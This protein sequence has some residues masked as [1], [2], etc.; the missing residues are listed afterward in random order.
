[1]AQRGSTSRMTTPTKEEVAA[2][3]DVLDLLTRR[4]KLTEALGSDR[5]LNE[6]D[7]QVLHYIAKHPDCGP[8]DLAR[9]LNVASTTISSATDR[10]VKRDLIERERPEADRRAVS[11][12]LTVTGR[13][14]VDS[15]AESYAKLHR[16]MLEPLSAAER[17]QIIAIIRKVVSYDP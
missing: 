5:P 13:L 8:T 3:G 6:I 16:R 10:L 17:H 7:K 1:M 9:F 11:L 14:R 4:Y 15:I 12:K 2:L